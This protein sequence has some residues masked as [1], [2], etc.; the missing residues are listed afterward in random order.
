MMKPFALGCVLAALTSASWAAPS[1][2]FERA[3]QMLDNGQCADARPIVNAGLADGDPQVYYLA[4]YMFSRGVC[5]ASDAPRAVKLLEAAAKAGHADAARELVLIHGL[6]RGVPQ[7]HAQAGRWALAAADIG[8]LKVVGAEPAKRTLDADYASTLG[9]LAT[10]HALVADDVRTRRRTYAFQLND[11]DVD[12][13]AT[14]AAA[15]PAP[16]FEAGRNGS[17]LQDVSTSFV[18]GS[19]PVV[20]M[21]KA[22]Y[23]KAAREAGPAPCARS[24]C[25]P[26]RLSREYAFRLE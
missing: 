25:A 17:P 9:H 26:I 15:D 24:A 5:V 19:G 23:Q 8:A 3:L 2:N 16:R 6:G 20:D 10:I 21:V 7:N 18:R 11:G 12:V 13:R 22:A 4:G 1:P 14:V